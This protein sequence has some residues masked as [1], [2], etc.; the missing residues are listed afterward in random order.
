L[1]SILRVCL[2]SLNSGRV[3]LLPLHLLELLRPVLSLI[4]PQSIEPFH[5]L[6]IQASLRYYFLTDPNNP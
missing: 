3:P 5:W 2:D 6:G 4:H 1:G